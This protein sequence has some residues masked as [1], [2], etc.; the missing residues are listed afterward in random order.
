M[1]L[2]DFKQQIVREKFNIK[3]DVFGKILSIVDFGNVN[4][5]FEE[6]RMDFAGNKINDNERFAVDLKMLFDFLG[7]ISVKSRF[8]FGHDQNKRQSLGFIGAARDVFGKRNVITKPMQFVK[9]YIKEDEIITREIKHN[10]DG[11]YILIPKC[12]FDVEISIDSVRLARD[13]DTV[14]LLSGDADFIALAQY[15]KSGLDKKVI[16]IKSGFIKSEFHNLADLVIN[17]QDI[18]QYITVKKQKSRP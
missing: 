2:I 1:D 11:N 13:Y 15:L 9:H 16:L 10:K 5:W 8:Y 14:C 6:D 4:Y 18:K 12:N 17:A 3:K 7:C